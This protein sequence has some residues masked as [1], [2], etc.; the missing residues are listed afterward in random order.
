MSSGI[1]VGY[2][3]SDTAKE[4]VRVAVEVAKAYGEKVVIA[5]GYELNPVAG[6][7]HDYHLALKD[8][9]TKRL[10]EATELAKT[11]GVEIEAV[12]VERSPAQGLVELADERDARVIVVGTRGE[13]PIRGALLGSTP[14]KLLHLADRPVLVVP[15]P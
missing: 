5:Y 9:A 8:T 15:S 14:H 2:D 13:S 7:L 6:E 10:N 11:D 4:A 3:G 1:V 12:I